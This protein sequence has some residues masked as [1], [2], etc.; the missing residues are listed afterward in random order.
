MNNKIPFY[1]VKTSMIRR[2]NNLTVN[3]K[4]GTLPIKNPR[5]IGIITKQDLY[6]KVKPFIRYLVSKQMTIKREGYLYKDSKVLISFYYSNAYEN[7]E[8]QVDVC[9]SRIDLRNTIKG[10]V[11]ILGEPSYLPP[12]EYFFRGSAYLKID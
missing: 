9:F 1:L 11:F 10:R 8:N 7:L 12:N 6:D 2:N 4:Y 3:S 5:N